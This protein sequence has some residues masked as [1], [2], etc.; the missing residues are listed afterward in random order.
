MGRRLRPG[1]AGQGGFTLTELMVGLVIVGVLSG[2]AVSFLGRTS[3][4]D[5][6]VQVNNLILEARQRAITLG[7]IRPDV[8]GATGITARTRVEF[9]TDGRTVRLWELRE[10]PRP[11]T[12]A[13]WVLLET[14]RIAP[15][16]E[17]YSVARTAAIDATSGTLVRLTQEPDPVSRNFFS[18]GTADPMTIYFDRPSGSQQQDKYRIVVFPVVGVPSMLNEW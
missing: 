15:E 13:T 11:A 2:L 9:A 8:F 10:D 12:T 6:A 1:P 4:R 18:N 16:I 14:M 3:S 5:S 7:P 17:I